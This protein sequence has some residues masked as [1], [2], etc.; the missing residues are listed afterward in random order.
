[1][2]QGY[3]KNPATALKYVGLLRLIVGDEFARA[4]RASEW[5]FTADAGSCIQA[6]Y[7]RLP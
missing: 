4:V 7:V 3:W 6:P 2:Q 5:H 1:M